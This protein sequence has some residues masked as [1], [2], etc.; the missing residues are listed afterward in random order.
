MNSTEIDRLIKEESRGKKMIPTI[1]VS[2]DKS[3]G[4]LDGEEN[5]VMKRL[6]TENGKLVVVKGNQ[7]FEVEVRKK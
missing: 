7:V 1:K 6:G 5:S 2:L 3:T 4:F